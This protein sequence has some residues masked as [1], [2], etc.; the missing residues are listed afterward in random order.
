[1]DRGISIGVFRGKVSW[2]LLSEARDRMM[3]VGEVD[4]DRLV[5][6]FPNSLR[7][8]PFHSLSGFPRYH[9]TKHALCNTNHRSNFEVRSS[10][11]RARGRG[12]SIEWVIQEGGGIC[13]RVIRRTLF[14]MEVVRVSSRVRGERGVKR[15]MSKKVGN[16]I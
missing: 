13:E 11:S 6:R 7:I 16:D 10:C 3:E 8:A 15:S 1:M 5:R 12:G 14:S 4:G 2:G 9:H